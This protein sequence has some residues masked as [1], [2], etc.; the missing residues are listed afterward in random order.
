MMQPCVKLYKWVTYDV[1]SES[2]RKMR[3][4]CFE[5]WSRQRGSKVTATNLGTTGRRRG[6]LTEFPVH[7]H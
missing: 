5:K 4:S 7:C 3:V 1:K 2:L 6:W